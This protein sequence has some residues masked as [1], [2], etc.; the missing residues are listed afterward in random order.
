M[1]IWFM[2][3]CSS[4]LHL[5][6]ENT[7][8]GRERSESCCGVLNS[9]HISSKLGIFVEILAALLLTAHMEPFRDRLNGATS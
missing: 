8:A 7:S 3:I 1:A 6:E 2:P 9:C 5:V 4:F